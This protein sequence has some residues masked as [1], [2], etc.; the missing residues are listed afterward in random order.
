MRKIL[1]CVFV[2]SSNTKE[3]PIEQL[4]NLVQTQRKLQHEKSGEGLNLGSFRLKKIFFK[5]RIFAIIRR[6][7]I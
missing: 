2:T 4:N 6:S 1:G 3:D 5:Y 7:R